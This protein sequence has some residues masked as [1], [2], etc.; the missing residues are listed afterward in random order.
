MEL[1]QHV[2]AQCEV[3]DSRIRRAGPTPQHHAVIDLVR[4][5]V[6]EDQRRD[7]VRRDPAGKGD[8]RESV[9]VDRLALSVGKASTGIISGVPALRPM[10]ISAM[11]RRIT[12]RDELVSIT[13]LISC[14]WTEIG[15]VILPFTMAMGMTATAECGQ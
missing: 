9:A 4:Q 5:A 12:V 3:G 14:P 6:G 13:A 2:H 15:T 7:I 1:V 8:L 10:I 11:S